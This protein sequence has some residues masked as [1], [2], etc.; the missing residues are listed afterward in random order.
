MFDRRS[1]EE[2]SV[3]AQKFIERSIRG[4]SQPF[5]SLT[6]VLAGGCTAEAQP[7]A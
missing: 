4:V 1:L 2:L 5:N 7:A 6:F 3:K